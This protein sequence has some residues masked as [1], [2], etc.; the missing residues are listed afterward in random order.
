MTGIECPECG[1]AFESRKGVRDHAWDA[2]GVCHHCG[3]PFEGRDELYEHWLDEHGAALSDTDRK[4]AEHRVGDR[5]VCPVC[6]DRFG[7]DDAVRSHAWDAHGAC[8]HCGAEFDDRETV[9]AHWLGAHGDRLARSTRERAE[10]A[11]GD[12]TFGQ[13]LAH[14]GPVDAVRGVRVRRRTLLGGGALGALALL[15]GAAA[16]GTLG[17]LGGGGGTLDTHPAARALASQ[18]TLGPAPADAEG[19][20]VAF[21]DPSCPS[22]AR[23]ERRTFPDLKARLVDPGTVSFVFRSIPVVNPWGRPATLALEAVHAREPAAFWGL[24]TFYFERQ[25]DIGSDNVRDVTRAYL[26]E[27]TDLDAESVMADVDQETFRDAVDTNLAAA[28]DAN[29]RGTPTFYL[30]GRESYRTKFVGPQS[31][32]VFKNALGV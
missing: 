10:S 14:Q 21:E 20:I 5:T 18:P 3:E 31:Y 27:Q 28:R 1:Q 2:H 24:K 16:T 23:F 8:H 4:R 26:D 11:V 17:N 30:F 13:R 19:T 12:L 7:S 6:G 15:G 25:R 32:D 9:A 29:L 22:C